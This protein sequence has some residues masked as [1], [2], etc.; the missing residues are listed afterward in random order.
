[1]PVSVTDEPR[2]AARPTPAER[3]IVKPAPIAA[4]PVRSIPPAATA[5]LAAP[6]VEAPPSASPPPFYGR[7]AEPERLID[8]SRERPEEPRQI[9]PPRAI[10]IEG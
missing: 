1:L 2:L 10:K 6:P 7:P 9:R 5:P 4:P 3:A 8:A